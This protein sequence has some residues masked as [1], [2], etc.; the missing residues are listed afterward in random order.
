MAKR[1][2]KIAKLTPAQDAA[3][4]ALALGAHLCLPNEDRNS[5]A[6]DGKR[7]TEPT[8]HGLKLRGLLEGDCGHGYRVTDLARE[9]FAEGITN[10]QIREFRAKALESGD[11]EMVAVCDHALGGYTSQALPT[12]M[13][14]AEARRDIAQAIEFGG[15]EFEGE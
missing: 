7:I 3:I 14:V 4:R 1:K 15:D 5:F 2:N 10:D 6:I 9:L 13:T 11:L 12:R 8:V